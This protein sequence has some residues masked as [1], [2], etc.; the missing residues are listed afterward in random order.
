MDLPDFISPVVNPPT[1]PTAPPI[2]V[3]TPGIT[4][5][6][7][8]PVEAPL[9]IKFIVWAFLSFLPLASDFWATAT[10]KSKALSPAPTKSFDS[11]SSLVF[12]S[13]SE[14]LSFSSLF[15]ITSDL[16]FSY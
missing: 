2:T 14:E 8:A 10:P 9:P 1:A 7:A 12:S 13:S 6:T 5:P 15:P 16:V 4:E 11:P 3:P